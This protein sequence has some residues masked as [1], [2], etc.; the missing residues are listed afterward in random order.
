M[1]SEWFEPPADTNLRPPSPDTAAAPLPFSRDAVKHLLLDAMR[2]RAITEAVNTALKKAV[3]KAVNYP[4]TP[5]G[6][7]A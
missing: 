4:K 7:S 3:N 2:D 5:S 1:M 6:W